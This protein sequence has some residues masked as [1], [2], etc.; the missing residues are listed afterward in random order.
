VQQ[1]QGA[2]CRAQ[3]KGG[4]GVDVIFQE[5][6]DTVKESRGR[7]SVTVESSCTLEKEGLRGGLDHGAYLG[8]VAR[9]L[10]EVCLHDLDACQGAGVELLSQTVCCGG[11]GVELLILRGGAKGL[12]LC[13]SLGVYLLVGN[14][15][16]LCSFSCCTFPARHYYCCG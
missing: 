2:A 1:G 14:C 4:A 3:S 15:V 11:H 9:N 16:S 8:V 5:N 7:S 6:G 13:F 10:R 12:L